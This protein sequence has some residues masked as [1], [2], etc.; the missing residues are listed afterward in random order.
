MTV[1]NTDVNV[2]TAIDGSRC[3][4]KKTS[5]GTVLNEIA[6]RHG[7]SR[8]ANGISLHVASVEVQKAL[9]LTTLSHG[10][11]MS[12]RDTILTTGLHFVDSIMIESTHG[13]G[14]MGRNNT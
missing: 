13:D 6:A 3:L 12:V 14:I 2:Q 11:L 4:T 8:F 10:T 1:S 5:T 9:R 7:L